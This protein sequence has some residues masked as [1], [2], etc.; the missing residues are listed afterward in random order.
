MLGSKSLRMDDLGV[1]DNC[2]T[3]LPNQD[4]MN[5]A[6]ITITGVCDEMGNTFSEECIAG[7]QMILMRKIQNSVSISI[8]SSIA[9][10]AMALVS[11]IN[12]HCLLRSPH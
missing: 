5:M 2:A 8:S 11:I 1:G 7:G 9:V 12:A 3:S 6:F 4:K 10:I